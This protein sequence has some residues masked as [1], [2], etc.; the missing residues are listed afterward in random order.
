[1][2][3]WKVSG[4]YFEVC[5]CDA[6]CPC[7]VFSPSTTGD[8]VVVLGWQIQ[9]GHYDQVDLSGLNVGMV[10]NAKGNM[11]DGNWRV[12]LYT[13]ARAK[14]NQAKALGAI[15]SGQAGGH[16]ANLGPLIGEVMGAKPANIEL[17]RN[18]KRFS[19]SIDDKMA[20][21][22]E[23][24]EGQGGGEVRVTGHPFAP[25]PNVPFTVGRSDR[26]RFSDYGIEVDVAGKSAFAAD[27][28]YHP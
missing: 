21:S 18:G 25:V 9:E 27:F 16:L 23:L 11:K 2:A 24:V 12:A 10:A 3:D 26:F 6:I 17:K 28:A 5:N 13:D 8:C 19:I 20:G 14:E 7:I 1:M 4:R 15:F 22:Y